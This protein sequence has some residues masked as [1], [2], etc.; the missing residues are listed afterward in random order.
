MK[1]ARQT[2]RTPKPKEPIRSSPETIGHDGYLKAVA[3]QNSGSLST[4]ASLF[5]T[6]L[7]Q[8]RRH[9][10]AWLGLGATL[11]DQGDL[12][13][14][15]HA[16]RTAIG[17]Q[18]GVSAGFGGLAEV[19]LKQGLLERALDHCG[20]AIILSRSAP[21]A[22]YYITA[23]K[24]LAESGLYHEALKALTSAWRIEPANPDVYF[25]M[26]L[27]YE[28][29]G[30]PAAAFDAYQ[31]TVAYRPR[32][33]RA[34]NNMAAVL[35]TLG[36]VE[37]AIA[38][39]R[40]AA[41]LAPRHPD[42]YLNLAAALRLHGDDDEA[43]GI[44]EKIVELDPDHGEALVELCHRRQHACDW[45]GL[46]SQQEEAWENSYR[47]GRV[48]SPFIVMT[49][50]A[51]P[52]EQL[53]CARV[54][55]ERLSKLAPAPLAPYRPT[56]VDQKH[57]K[58]RLGYLSADFHSH[59]TAMLIVDMLEQHDKTRFELFGYSLGPDDGS[60]LRQRVVDA[61]DHFADLRGLSDAGAA[62]KIH[63]NQID[64]LLDLKGYTQGARVKILAY[65]PAPIQVNYLGFPGTMGAPFIDYIVADPHV[66]PMAHQA[67]FDEKIVHLPHCYQPNDRRRALPR[68]LPERAEFGL[69]KDGFV[70]CC[71]NNPYKITAEIFDIWMRLLRETPGSVLWLLA[72]K[73]RVAK[74][75]LREASARGIGPGRLVFAPF[76]APE[77]HLARLA[78][79]DLFLDTLPVN[80]H[81]TASEALW[82][83][84]P[85]ITCQGET[86]AS[87]VA[88]SL[89]HAIEM[90]D[91]VTGSLEAYE[92]L[93]MKLAHDPAGLAAIRKRLQDNRLNTA[94][95][96]TPRYTKNFEAA[97]LRMDELR[98]SGQP[99]RPFAVDV[100]L[101]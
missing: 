25:Q 95:F 65:E 52:I 61:F 83:G 70:F 58:L 88:A 32:D 68:G 45:D 12:K 41:A 93:A 34:Y 3:A 75:L 42:V 46:A 62:M 63:A 14:A 7:E 82:A 37:L 43:Q 21:K 51:S 17:L 18:P 69:P 87:R 48:V 66:A 53:R 40:M 81:T 27:I 47:K 4:A 101:K 39:A 56:A 8:D 98:Q 77:Q 11:K 94:L 36:Q 99:P 30:E 86:F 76:V 71:F 96:D 84:L 15:E 73:K 90:P 13:G 16:Y 80:A 44:Y 57:S 74:N 38:T 89:L 10:E 29:Q 97:L 31:K 5:R 22:D 33:A 28:D 2:K 20:K 78:L 24:A 35:I 55:G 19:C 64:I 79:A 23:A 67:H 9:I 49:A 54:W 100:N 50:T 91:L 72:P 6:C 26:G 85:L 92:A 1:R 60:I 59:A